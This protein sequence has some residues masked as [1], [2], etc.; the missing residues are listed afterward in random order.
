MAKALDGPIGTRRIRPYSGPAGTAYG[1]AV[2]QGAT[3]GA[4]ILPTGSGQRC[5]GIVAESDLDQ[6]GE[7]GVV[8]EGETLAIIGAAVGADV[9]LIANAAGQLIP[10][11]ASGDQ[12]LAI[13]VTSGAALGD[14]I[15]V[16][17]NRFIK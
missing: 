14:E 13:S 11:A 4:V 1:L 12:V 15:V 16:K 6:T 9:D 8:V 7:L 17:L 2:K 5:L 3:D 10:S